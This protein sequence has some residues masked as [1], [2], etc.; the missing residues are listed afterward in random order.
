M[1]RV[2]DRAEHPKRAKPKGFRGPARSEKP[3]QITAWQD[4]YMHVLLQGQVRS[5]FTVGT[6]KLSCLYRVH[7]VCIQI[8]F[9]RKTQEQNRFF[10]GTEG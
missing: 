7:C 10:T 8:F 9:F 5:L 4:Q 3:G 6:N 1:E 2:P